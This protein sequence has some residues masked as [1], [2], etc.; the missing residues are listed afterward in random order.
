MLDLMGMRE[1]KGGEMGGV[2]VVDGMG[3]E[4]VDWRDLSWA[5]VWNT[6]LGGTE[7][8]KMWDPEVDD[9]DDDHLML[10]LF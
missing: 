5:W 7:R 8:K 1:W 4:L 2:L 6:A 9:D 10:L 3:M